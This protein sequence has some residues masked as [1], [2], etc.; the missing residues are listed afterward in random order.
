M[1]EERL[2][3]RRSASMLATSRDKV[4]CRALAMSRRPFQKSSSTLI[5]VR[6]PAITIERLMTEDFMAHFPRKRPVTCDLWRRFY[7]SLWNFKI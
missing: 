4:S 6:R 1:A 2:A 5:L 3:C 7:D